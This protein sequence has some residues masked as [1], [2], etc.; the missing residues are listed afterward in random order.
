MA[1]FKYKALSYNNISNLISSSHHLFMKK[2]S[3]YDYILQIF[4][5]KSDINLSELK[6]VIV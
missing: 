2:F 4:S 1:T 6:D 5:K 3:K